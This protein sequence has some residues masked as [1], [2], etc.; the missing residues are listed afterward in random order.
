MTL[1]YVSNK[2]S[3]KICVGATFNALHP[4]VTDYVFTNEKNLSNLSTEFKLWSDIVGIQQLFMSSELLIEKKLL[5]IKKKLKKGIN[6]EIKASAGS[7]FKKVWDILFL[8]LFV[9]PV[10]SI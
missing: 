6:F 9:E 7:K 2:V 10:Q 8:N 3:Y 5:K 1:F 4:L